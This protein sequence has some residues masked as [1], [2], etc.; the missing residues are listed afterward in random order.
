[1]ADNA[2][3]VIIHGATTAAAGVGA[4]LAQIPG[5]D[6]PVL[7]SIQTAMIL[8]IGQHYGISLTKTAAADLVLTFAASM[9]GR[10]VS[11]FLIGWIPGLGNAINASTAAAITEAIGWSADTYLSARQGRRDHL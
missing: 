7:M 1:M 5:S 4:G 2:V 9:A 11:Q 8:G 3:H 6:A 10:A